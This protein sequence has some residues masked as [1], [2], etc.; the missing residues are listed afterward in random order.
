MAFWR[1]D[2]L[3]RELDAGAMLR[4]VHANGARVFFM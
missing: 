3:A 1:V 4:G 2:A